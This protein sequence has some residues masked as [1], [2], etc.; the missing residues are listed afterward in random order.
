MT[1]SIK[2]QD[3]NHESTHRADWDDEQWLTEFFEFLK[4]TAPDG[5]KMG[6]GHQPKLSPKKAFSIIWYLQ[7]HMRVLPDRIDQCWR[8]G[9]LFDSWREGLYWESKGRN[10]CGSCDHEVPE[11]Y[12]NNRRS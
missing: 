9:G 1:K 3:K 8:C 11:N 5:I 7:E 2:F 12:D 4:G 10:Y 6:H